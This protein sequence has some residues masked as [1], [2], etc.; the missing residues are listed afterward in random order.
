MNANSFIHLPLQQ[1]LSRMD[2]SDGAT[3]NRFHQCFPETNEKLLIIF[4]LVHFE[5]M[6]ICGGKIWSIYEK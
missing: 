3:V 4:T 6:I 5:S 1:N 2:P